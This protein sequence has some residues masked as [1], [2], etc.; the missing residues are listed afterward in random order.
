MVSIGDPKAEFFSVHEHGA[1]NTSLQMMVKM[2]IA[3]AIFCFNL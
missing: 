2:N 3:I 1:A